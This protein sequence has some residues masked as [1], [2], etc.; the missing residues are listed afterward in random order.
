VAVDG[1]GVKRREVGAYLHAAREPGDPERD[2]V[3]GEV[4]YY[5]PLVSSSNGCCYSPSL[6]SLAD[7]GVK[8]EA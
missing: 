7:N 8:T 5:D 6:Y 2:G 3:G 1:G 4:I